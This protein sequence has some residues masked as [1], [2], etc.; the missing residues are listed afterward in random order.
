MLPCLRL[1]EPSCSAARVRE[2]KVVVIYS[3]LSAV[4]FYKQQ[5]A[6]RC[7][8]LKVLQVA[9]SQ[10][11]QCLAVALANFCRFLTLANDAGLFEEAPTAHFTQY[12]IALNDLVE[13]FER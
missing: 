2:S 7:A 5:R 10:E 11:L 12:P 9:R 3:S 8:L 6:L 13:A 1:S 4:L